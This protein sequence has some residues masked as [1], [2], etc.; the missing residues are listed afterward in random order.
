M[1]GH[2]DMV[3]LIGGGRC[4]IRHAGHGD[5]LVLAHQ[6]RRRDL[7]DHQAGVE[8]GARCQEGRKVEGEGG[9]HHQRHAALG[10][11]TDF[12]QCQRDHVGCEAHGFG[13]E[14][15]ARNDLPTAGEYQRIVRCG[16]RLDLQ[17]AGGL[18]Q[19]I[20]RGTRHLWLAADAIGV[21]DALVAR[22]MAFT[23]FR[24]REQ[25]AHEVRR[26]DLP[27]MAAQGVDLAGERGGRSH[28]GIRREGRYDQG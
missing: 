11:R 8:A 28:D 23:D 7:G 13:V 27:G 14:I 12:R 21:L 9:V 6:R 4:R 15:A 2:A 10:D 24:A 19:H 25:G 5:V 22:E 16:I 3:F 18:P 1:G 17:R 26:L 20:H